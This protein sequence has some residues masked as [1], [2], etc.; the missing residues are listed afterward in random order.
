MS[1]RRTIAIVWCIAAFVLMLACWMTYS[2]PYRWAADRQLE[3]FGS[4]E[5][6]ITLFGPLIILMIPAGF[7]GGWG[8]PRPRT[9]A[10]PEVRVANARRIARVIGIAGVVA[11][12]IGAA[13]GALGYVKMQ[14]P[15]SHSELRLVKGDETAPAADLVT[16]T[17]I[18]RPDLIVGYQE[19]ISG[20]ASHWSFVPLVSQAWKPGDPIRFLLKTNQTAWMPPAGTAMPHML[21]GGSPPFSMMTQPSVLKSHDLP[22]IVRAEYEKAR[23]PLDPSVIV[24]EQSEGEVLAPYWMTAAGG[25]LLGACLLLAGLLGAINAKKAAR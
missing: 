24:V 17:G 10:T 16:V 7:I 5:L 18:A 14:T 22:G 4:Y 20:M 1:V 25:G 23:I 19:T 9:V 21:T 6:K 15:M 12:A 8:P 13:G 2:G 11:L 3:H